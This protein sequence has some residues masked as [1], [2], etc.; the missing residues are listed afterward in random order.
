MGITVLCASVYMWYKKTEHFPFGIREVRPLLV[1]RGLFGF[2]G[3]FGMYCKLYLPWV[4]GVLLVLL[5]LQSPGTSATVSHVQSMPTT[6]YHLSLSHDLV[7]NF[8]QIH[9]ST[10]HSPTLLSL[11]S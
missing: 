5:L 1:A 7:T 6:G 2:F 3:V 4:I 8:G 11:P 10:C 9:S